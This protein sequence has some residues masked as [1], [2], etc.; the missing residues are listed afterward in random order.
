MHKH[1]VMPEQLRRMLGVASRTTVLR[2]VNGQIPEPKIMQRIIEIT[3]GEVQLVDFLDPSPPKCAQVIVDARG[4]RRKVFPW[5]RGWKAQEAA[6]RAECS[7]PPEGT[8]TPQPVLRA[9]AV[10][11]PR[12]KPTKRGQYLLDGRICD[13][14]RVVREANIILEA[15]GQPPIPY[16]GIRRPE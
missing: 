6:F 15:E 10:L 3:K 9:L 8:A 2:Y 5:S 7:A 12:V 1:Q 14:R 16:P 4:R 11:G 13:A